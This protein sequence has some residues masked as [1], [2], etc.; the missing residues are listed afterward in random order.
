[1]II[2]FTY[3]AFFKIH[4]YFHHRATKYDFYEIKILS[5]RIPWK[6]FPSKTSKSGSFQFFYLFVRRVH[7]EI[8]IFGILT[9]LEINLVYH[10]LSKSYQPVIYLA[11]FRNKYFWL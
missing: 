3:N 10:G 9:R 7:F 5:R 6:E 2:E 4:N 11:E 8:T 1:M